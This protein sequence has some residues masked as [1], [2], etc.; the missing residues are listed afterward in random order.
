MAAA[1]API[2]ILRK[3]V[4]VL[5]APETCWA[6][7]GEAPKMNKRENAR[8]TGFRKSDKVKE[9]LDRGTGFLTNKVA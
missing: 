6:F 1:L 8:K 2:P 5:P 9:V 7:I 4:L 3:L